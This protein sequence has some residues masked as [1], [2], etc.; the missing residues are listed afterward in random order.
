MVAR[1]NSGKGIRGVLNYN[2]DKVKN[3][4]AELLMAAGFPRDPDQLSFK[5]K[6][7]RFEMLTRQNKDTRTNTLHITLNFSREDILDVELLKQIAFDYMERIGFGDQPFLVYQHFD[8]AHPHL[9]LATVNIADG[10]QRIETHNIGKNQSEK[11][12]KEIE[13]EYGLI[14]AEDQQKEAAYR[15]LPVDLDKVIYGKKE[16][17]A[18]IS[19]IVR[20]VVSSYKFTS[21]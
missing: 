15:L 19:A 16:T 14:K 4:E 20:E 9:H 2:E 3:A 18:A 6:L 7:E 11:A 1:I 17:K 10:G 5:S 8:A 21:L 12:R 13:I